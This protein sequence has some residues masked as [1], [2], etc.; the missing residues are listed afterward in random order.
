MLIQGLYMAAKTR[1][2]D[3]ILR[4]I[5]SCSRVSAKNGGEISML[6]INSKRLASRVNML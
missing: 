5:G 3:V 1:L 2:S 6:D 4:L